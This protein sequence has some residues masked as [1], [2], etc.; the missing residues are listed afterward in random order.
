[1]RR[2]V[3]S[4]RA[5]VLDPRGAVHT[6]AAEGHRAQLHDRDGVGRPEAREEKGHA[7]VPSCSSLGA[8]GCTPGRAPI[9][10]TV[11]G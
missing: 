5:A 7:C 6:H 4:T 3:E 9:P 1:M 2:H 10:A 8:G 11:K